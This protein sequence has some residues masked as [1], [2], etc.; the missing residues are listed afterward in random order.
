MDHPASQYILCTNKQQSDFYSLHTACRSVDG[1]RLSLPH[2][3]LSDAKR[4]ALCL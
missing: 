1:L 3:K 2:Y 4:Q